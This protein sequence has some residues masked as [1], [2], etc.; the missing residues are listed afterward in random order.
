MAG[1]SDLAD[2][3]PGY[4]SLGEL[5]DLAHYL[6]LFSIYL[7][8]PFNSPSGLSQVVSPPSQT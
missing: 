4:S 7:A 6:E 8:K 3:Q 2:L 1:K 5:E